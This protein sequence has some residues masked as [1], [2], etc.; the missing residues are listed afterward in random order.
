MPPEP[1]S[2]LVVGRVRALAATVVVAAARRAGE[3]L[4]KTWQLG[5]HSVITPN[6]RLNVFQFLPCAGPELRTLLPGCRRQL[7]LTQLRRPSR[8]DSSP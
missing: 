8:A 6:L 1:G 2:V 3:P 4:N 7:G 5:S